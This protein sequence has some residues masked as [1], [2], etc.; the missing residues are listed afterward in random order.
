MA[1]VVEGDLMLAASN[2]LSA[3]SSMKLAQFSGG[4]AWLPVAGSGGGGEEN[5]GEGCACLREDETLRGD[6]ACG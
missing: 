6:G 2:L 4:G 5:K 1:G 3:Q